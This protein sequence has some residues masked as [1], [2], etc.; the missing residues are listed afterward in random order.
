MATAQQTCPCE[1]RISEDSL[2][3]HLVTANA[4][5]EDI[6]AG[7][8]SDLLKHQGVDV[9]DRILKRITEAVEEIKANGPSEAPILLAEGK[10]P[11]PAQP[12]RFE[13]TRVDQQE[14]P[15][16]PHERVDFHR[17][18]IVTVDEGEP[19]GHFFQEVSPVPGLDLYGKPIAAP[20]VRSTLSLGE[21]VRLAD[22]GKTVIAGRA[23]KIH[24]TRSIIDIEDVV[25]IPGDV[26]YSSGNVDVHNAVLIEGTVRESFEVKSTKS[27]TIRG[28]IEPANVEAGTDLQVNGGIAGRQIAR[29]VAGGEIHTKFCSEANLVAGSDIT[30]TREVMN[31]RL[32]TRGQLHMPNGAVIGGYYYL[33]MGGEIGT[34]GSDNEVKTTIAIGS[35]PGGIVK[36]KEIEETIAKKKAAAQKIRS[37]VQPLMAQMKRL[38][39][40]QR[41]RA[42]ELMFQADGMDLE[43][44]DCQTEAQRALDTPDPDADLTLLVNQQVHAGVK[45]VI[46]NK[47]TVFRKPRRGSCKI[48]RRAVD[49]VEQIVLIDRLT[50]SVNPMPT[51]DFDPADTSFPGP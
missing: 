13:L 49:R 48:V 32:H 41:E 35:D 34:I 3:A 25:D 47:F 21:H 19:I 14:I 43:I 46:G 10:P 42:T 16:D 11:V 38:T 7:L 23:G 44:N 17:S 27:V 26:D 5:P 51:F 36:A 29:I 18:L 12:A 9:G 15:T 8:V 2:Y 39:P 40:S 6:T 45:I 50:G 4:K 30:I 22:D 33:R 24:L 1:V 28:A 37:A 31:S 20:P